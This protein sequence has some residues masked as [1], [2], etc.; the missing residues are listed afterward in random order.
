[1]NDLQIKNEERKLQQDFFVTQIKKESYI[2]EIKDG[3]GN[4]IINEPNKIQKK[5][6]FWGK[7]KKMFLN[8]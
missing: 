6:S 3:L 1:M 4:K 7:I 5:I 8:G 2:K